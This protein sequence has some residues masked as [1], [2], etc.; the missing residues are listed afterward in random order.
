MKL[1]VV[2]KAID[3]KKAENILV[4][5][6]VQ[7]NPSVDK[8][9]ICSAN[10]NRQVHAIADNIKDRLAQHGYRIGHI[11][12]DKASNWVLVDCGE[13]VV[14]VFS[15]EE[16]RHYQLEKLYVGLPCEEVYL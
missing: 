10:N 16:R 15:Y 6:F 14:H 8:V 7:L 9:V 1:S 13:I 12:G 2:L 11:E 5:D 4:Y 3:E